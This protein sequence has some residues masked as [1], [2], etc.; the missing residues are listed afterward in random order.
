MCGKRVPRVGIEQ[1][2]DEVARNERSECL[3]KVAARVVPPEPNGYDSSGLVLSYLV[4]YSIGQAGLFDRDE[5]PYFATRSRNDAD[6]ARKYEKGIIRG[7]GEDKP[8]AKFQQG[9]NDQN[10]PP[11]EGI[12]SS[13]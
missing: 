10:V 8:G 3:S 9:A 7:G 6:N 2:T 13:C 12:C 11:S 1:H 4:Y 5:G